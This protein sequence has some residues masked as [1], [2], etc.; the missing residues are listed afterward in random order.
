M[1]LCI[2]GKNSIAVDTLDYALT[3]WDRNKILGL[4]N[5]TD[6]GEDSWQPSFLKK[7]REEKLNIVQLQELY[8]QEMIFIS[9]EY[10]RIIAPRKFL[11]KYLYNIHFSKLPKYRG[12]YTSA[13]PIL[14]GESE[15]GVTLHEIDHGIDTGD[16]IDQI[17]FPI[18]RDDTARDLYFKYLKYGS[19]LIKINLKMVLEHKS[20]SYPQPKE[21][22]S[23]Y[24]KQ[25]INY[26]D[27]KIDFKQTS[28]MV[29]KQVRAYT[30]KEY[31]L[32]KFNNKAIQRIDILDSRSME[33]PSK[34]VYEENAYGIMATMD[35][36]IKLTWGGVLLTI[37]NAMI[38][39]RKRKQRNKVFLSA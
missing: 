20:I 23:Y 3:I 32:P 30:F 14:N 37:N 5:K 16:I 2:A 6:A 12:M 15:T 31:Q 27:L 1:Y 28:D 21:G 38:L 19:M 25:S 4:P 39:T 26:S 7:C 33:K 11:S 17:S 35:Y 22:A 8:N 13:W 9:L 36:D 34:L 24:S 18:F 10:D 29:G